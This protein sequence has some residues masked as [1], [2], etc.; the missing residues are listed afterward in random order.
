M[1]HNSKRPSAIDFSI[2][3][4]TLI[5]LQPR[6]EIR[7]VFIWAY[8][9]GIRVPKGN[10]MLKPTTKNTLFDG[11]DFPVLNKFILDESV[12]LIH[13]VPPFSSSHS[14]TLFFMDKKLHWGINT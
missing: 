2:A 11:G 7:E 10:L 9:F 3:E 5:Y 13:L 8:N 12:D 4:I 6:E 1:G 14:C